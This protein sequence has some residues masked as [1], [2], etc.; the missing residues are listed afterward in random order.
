M[1]VWFIAAMVGA[2]DGPGVAAIATI[3]DASP[4]AFVL[5]A[6]AIGKSG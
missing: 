2:A 3:P 4:A 5:F 1:A 6:N